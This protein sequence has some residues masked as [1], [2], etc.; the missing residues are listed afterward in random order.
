MIRRKN[1]I[2]IDQIVPEINGKFERTI[3]TLGSAFKNSGIYE[4]F[5]QYGVL[6]FKTNS[7]FALGTLNLLDSNY[8]GFEIYELG[9]NFYATPFPEGV[10]N[11]IINFINF[12]SLSFE[13]SDSNLSNPVGWSFAKPQFI[14]E[15]DTS[16]KV[17][18][19]NS[20]KLQTNSEKQDWSWVFSRTIPISFGQ[21][22]IETNMK[23]DNVVSS[24]ISIYETNP[25]GIKLI[26][27]L[28]SEVEGKSDWKNFS[29]QMNLR[30]NKTAIQF[31]LNAGWVQDYNLGNAT[32][33]FDGLKVCRLI[34]DLERCPFVLGSESI[35]DLKEKI[36]LHPQVG[37]YVIEKN[38]EGFDIVMYGGD[39][40]ALPMDEIFEP[41]IIEQNG[42]RDDVLVATTLDEVKMLVNNLLIPKPLFPVSDE[43]LLEIWNKRTD[44]Q[45]DFPEVSQGNFES[46]K[47]WA[48]GTGWN[49]ESSLSALIPEGQVSSYLSPLPA[50]EPEELEIPSEPENENLNEIVMLVIISILVGTGFIFG[51]KK[52]LAKNI[53]D[54]KTTI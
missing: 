20:F 16:T 11:D 22:L 27:Q 37:P 26:N 15:L 4:I 42:T 29:W 52:L 38:Y 12:E 45:Q 8:K 19:D 53:S 43:V 50:E 32:T 9:E 13:K 14:V 6:E 1:L 5:A 31:V 48:K 36:A 2:Y 41:Q 30:E 54:K 18:G 34:L 44:L 33:W 25:S 35:E 51:F 40:F 21:Y 23:W 3:P 24:H 28:P 49:E 10:Y 17:D 7:Q 47:I 39:F 46:F